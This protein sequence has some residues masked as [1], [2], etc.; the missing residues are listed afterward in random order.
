MTTY[1]ICKAFTDLKPKHQIGLILAFAF[2]LRLLVAVQTPYPSRDAYMYLSLAEFYHTGNTAQIADTHPWMPPLYSLVLCGLMK[3]S[4]SVET[5]ALIVS[6]LGSFVILLSAYAIT[7]MLT[8]KH[9]LALLSLFFVAIHRDMI[10]GA[11]AVEREALY[12]PLIS[13]TL[14]FL[15]KAFS[16]HIRP[17]FLF[18]SFLLAGLA[19][20]CR[21]EALQLVII[22]P[23]IIAFLFFSD[24]KQCKKITILSPLLIFVFFLPS[25][26][27]SQFI[28]ESMGSQWDPLNKQRTQLLIDNLRGK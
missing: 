5:A 9:H 20:T 6:M 22:L 15:V 24:R 7:L 13:L 28:N 8:K 3:L 23:I 17:S 16:E 19:Y 21:Q 25:L 27:L 11:S 1:K 26:I 18:P 4:L 14:V 10:E 12:Y 2:I